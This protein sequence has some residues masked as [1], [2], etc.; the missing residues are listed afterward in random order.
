MPNSGFSVGDRVRRL[1]DGAVGVVAE[2]GPM[3]SIGVRWDSS[4]VVS[5][6]VPA[7]IKPT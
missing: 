6:V 1:N 7:Q 3:G 5:V 4:G 2:I